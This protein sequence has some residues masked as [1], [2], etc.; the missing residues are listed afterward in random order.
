MIAH[1]LNSIKNADNIIVMENGKIAEQG[2]HAEL[3]AK[4]LICTFMVTT[5][6]VML[7]AKCN[8]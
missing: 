3:L 6:S 4:W 8:E 2:K 1:R 5:E 7:I